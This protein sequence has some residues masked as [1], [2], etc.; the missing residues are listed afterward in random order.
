MCGVDKSGWRSENGERTT[1]AVRRAVYTVNP[2]DDGCSG[3]GYDW[4]AAGSRGSVRW[5]WG[6]V[7]GCAVCPR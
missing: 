4:I 3:C 5:F 7:P 1:P 2:A 6:C